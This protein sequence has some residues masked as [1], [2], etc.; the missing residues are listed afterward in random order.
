VAEALNLPPGDVL[1]R[2][3]A[4]DPEMIFAVAAA[5]E[6]ENQRVERWNNLFKMLK[7]LGELWSK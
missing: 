2:V 4:G 3:Q 5:T 6:R 1:G 7:Q